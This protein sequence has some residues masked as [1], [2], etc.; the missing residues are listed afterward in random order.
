[1]AAILYSTFLNVFL[2]PTTKVLSLVRIFS[3][4]IF[5][6]G[7]DIY[8]PKISDEFDYGG[9]GSLNMCIINRPFNEPISFVFRTSKS[10]LLLILEISYECKYD[11]PFNELMYF[12]IPV[13][14]VLT[15]AIKIG[16]NVGLTMLLQFG[17]CFSL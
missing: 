11:G 3:L 15:K 9:S 12:D 7:R 8:C 14:I 5:K 17:A 10:L 2:T 13:L 16:T 4:N 1:M 6:H